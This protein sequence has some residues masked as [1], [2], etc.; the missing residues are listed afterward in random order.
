M[1]GLLITGSQIRREVYVCMF[2]WDDSFYSFFFRRSMLYAY[3][4]MGQ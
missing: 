1:A 4:C 2:F 3:M